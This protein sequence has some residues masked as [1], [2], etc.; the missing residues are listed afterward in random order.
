MRRLFGV[1]L[2]AG[3][4]PRYNLAPTQDLLMVCEDDGERQARL[5]RWGL[6]STVDQPRNLSTFSAR[7]ETAPRSPIFREAYRTRRALIPVQ[8]AYKWTGDKK[9]RHPLIYAGL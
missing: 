2:P 6:I 8:G 3:F 9:A 1:D 7:V 4:G 5:A